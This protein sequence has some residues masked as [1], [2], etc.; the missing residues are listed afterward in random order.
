MYRIAWE[1]KTTEAKGTG[2]YTTSKTEAEAI[3]QQANKDHPGVFHWVEKW[4]YAEP[5]TTDGT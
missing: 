4:T 2:S 5:E 1:S 3:A